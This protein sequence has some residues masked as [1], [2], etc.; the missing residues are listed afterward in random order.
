M[1]SKAKLESCFLAANTNLASVASQL[2]WAP[3]ELPGPGD[4]AIDFLD[5]LRTI[6]GNGDANLRDGFALHIFT[7]SRAMDRRAFLNADGECLFVAQHGNLD[8]KTEMGRM[9]LQPGEIAVIPRGIKYTLDP[10]GDSP[11]ARGY[12]IE[13]F[14]TKWELPNLG[15]IGSQGLA[16][17]RD[18]LVPVAY[19]DENLHETWNIVVKLSGKLHAIEQDH[20]PF[21]VAAWHGNCVPYKVIYMPEQN[22]STFS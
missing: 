11:E 22:H 18:F 6:G 16:N 13:L 20:S 2:E 7:C 10:A 3:F 12:I 1:E 19:I 8:I 14:G 9:F 21:D 4:E 17:S 5:G 15:P